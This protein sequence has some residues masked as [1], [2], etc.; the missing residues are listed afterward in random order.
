MP[1]IYSVDKTAKLW[2]FGG[3]SE[4]FENEAVQTEG[5]KYRD[6]FQ[7]Q[8]Q[9][10]FSRVQHHWHA[11]EKGKRVPLKYCRLSKGNSAG[12]KKNMPC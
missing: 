3:S 10:V 7:N 1:S 9:F 2:K 12:K 6:Q 5:N 4:L 11:L 8:V